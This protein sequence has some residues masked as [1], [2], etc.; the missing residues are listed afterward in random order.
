MPV[1]RW[2]ED[3]ACAADTAGDRLVQLHEHQITAALGGVS[4]SRGLDQHLTHGSR[5]D[6]PE[7]QGREHLEPRC[8]S[9]FQKR[10]VD[11]RRRAQR[12]GRVIATDERR[13]PPQFLIG[14]AEQLVER[15]VGWKGV[16]QGWRESLEF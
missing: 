15:R 1:F 9:Q 5:D 12:G 6:A 2:S 7:M 8:G 11:E 10:L 13:Q 14:G 3:V 4:P 16:W